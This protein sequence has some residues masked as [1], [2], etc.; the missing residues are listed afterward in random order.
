MKYETAGG[1]PLL[2]EIVDYGSKLNVPTTPTRSN[3][4]FAG[5]YRDV[6]YTIAWDFATHTVQEDLVLYAKW[7]YCG[8]GGGSQ[9][10]KTPIFHAPDHIKTVVQN[11]EMF[12][13]K[14]DKI[15][16]EWIQAHVEMAR[17]MGK[18][19]IIQIGERGENNQKFEL[20]QGDMEFVIIENE[21]SYVYFEPSIN[22]AN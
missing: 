13:Q 17:K 14:K 9:R 18:Y 15:T 6:N 1:T 22:I 19:Y 8:G 12:I 4:T 5:W 3:Y 10:P 11:G 21:K 16:G 20:P 7:N 2:D